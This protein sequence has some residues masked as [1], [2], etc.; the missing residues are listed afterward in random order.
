MQKILTVR[1]SKI[2]VI[3]GSGRQVGM[4]SQG[5]KQ[6]GLL[7][8]NTYLIKPMEAAYPLFVILQYFSKCAD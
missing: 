5:H 7:L 2:G 6:K 8:P 4:G 3:D 1:R